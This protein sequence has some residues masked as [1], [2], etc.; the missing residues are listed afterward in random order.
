MQFSPAGR[1][2]SVVKVNILVLNHY[3][4]SIQHGMEF[5]PY[6]LA[7]E[8]VRMGHRVR[9]VAASY[10]H[11]RIQSP[12]MAGRRYVE[13]I[14]DG[15]EYCWFATPSYQGNGLARLRNVAS[16]VGALLREGRR[17]AESFRPDVVI[18]SSTYP[19]DIFPAR[20][21]ARFA[22]ARLLFEVHDLWPLSPMEL[23]GFSRYHPFIMLLQAAENYACRHADAVVSILPNVA[24]HLEAHGMRSDKLHHIPNGGDPAEWLKDAPLPDSLK[25]CLTDARRAQQFIVGYAGSHGTANAL[26]DLLDAARLL[27]NCPVVFILVGDGPEKSR[28]QDAAAAQGRAHVHFADPVAKCQIPAFL[29]S[30]DLAYLGWRRHSLYRF[31]IAP[32][33]LVDYMMAGCPILHAVDAA[34]DLVAEARCGLSVLPED[35]HAIADG[36]VSLMGQ[37]PAERTRMGARGRQFALERLSYPVLSRRFLKILSE[38]ASNG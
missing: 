21:I 13:E 11:L 28:L 27:H 3:A 17:L 18:A 8:W 5:R 2:D 16:F 37:S 6:Y 38:E 22:R 9:I 19:L 31:G 29:R 26:N 30:I 14:L 25:T 32:N 36:V 15:I 1:R 12:Q 10:S 34:N 24:A 23:A 35:A 20:R 7:R 4:G 33:K